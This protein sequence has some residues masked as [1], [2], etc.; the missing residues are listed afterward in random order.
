MTKKRHFLTKNHR[1]GGSKV[2]F[3]RVRGGS[4]TG[5]EG[6]IWGVPT[7][8]IHYKT[9]ILTVA[10]PPKSRKPAPADHHVSNYTVRGLQLRGRGVSEGT[11]RV[12]LSLLYHNQGPVRGGFQIFVMGR[13]SE[14]GVPTKGPSSSSPHTFS[15]LTGSVFGPFWSL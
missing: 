5:L 3:Q 9:T 6:T 2:P 1:F 13:H 10:G 15:L 12:M 8:E 7:T 11:Q 14:G 4:K